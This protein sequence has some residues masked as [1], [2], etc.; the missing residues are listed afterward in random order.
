MAIIKSLDLGSLES[1]CKILGETNN[2]LSGTEITKYL[3]E[4]NIK[5]LQ[6]NSTKWK[7]LY[8]ALYSKQTEDR[9]SNNVLN[10]IRYVIRPSRHIH[11]KEWFENIR[12]E[13]NYVLSFEGLSLTESGE[14]KQAD[15]VQTF[16]EAEARAQNLRKALLDRKIHPDVLA[17][18]KAE[19]LVDN[20]FH[21]VFEATKSIAEKIRLKTK[22]TSDG[23]ELVDQAFSYKAKIPYLALNRLTTESEESE[24]SEQKG[25]MNLLKGVFGT[26][27]NT[28]PHVPKIKWN[29]EEQDALDT[30]SMISL[31]HQYIES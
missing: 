29:I 25:F 30:L 17:L 6:L 10:F 13:L 27:R 3:V 4:C 1:I 5:D 24:E 11:R 28:T 20:Y 8:D 31:I 26:F 23:A 16:D 14:L 18:C 21:A 22:L 15:K 9:C 12:N 19:L 7:R 2:G